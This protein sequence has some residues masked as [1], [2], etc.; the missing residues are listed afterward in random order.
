LLLGQRDN[1]NT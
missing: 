1:I